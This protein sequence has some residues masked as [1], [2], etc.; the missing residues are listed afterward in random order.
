MYVISTVVT[1]M[2]KT[3][4]EVRMKV[5]M[6]KNNIVEGNMCNRERSEGDVR[7]WTF[8]YPGWHR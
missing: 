6:S 4:L 3:D 8:E 7:R 2:I 5:V 1:N